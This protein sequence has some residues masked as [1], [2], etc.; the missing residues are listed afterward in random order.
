MHGW[1]RQ[2]SGDGHCRA[3]LSRSP[4]GQQ[5][6]S[7]VEFGLVL[8]LL[9][10]L[11]FGII[12]FGILFSQKLALENG[13]RQASR[14]AVV[15]QQTCSTITAEAQKD[16]VGLGIGA[17]ATTVTVK[18][19][20]SLATAVDACASGANT[21][22]TNSDPQTNVYVTVRFTGS[23]SIPLVVT[24]SIGLQGTGVFR[25]EYS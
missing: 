8:P 16:A 6:A 15:G 19:G 20:T 2:L 14:F 25:C 12:S 10:I 9:V 17:S 7:A 4:R 13:A 22:C 5:G 1:K 11:V 3:R 21:P 18:A 24:K 23:L